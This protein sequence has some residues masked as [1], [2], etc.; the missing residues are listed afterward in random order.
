[1]EELKHEEDEETIEFT[2]LMT[3]MTTE[4]SGAGSGDEN[5][6]IPEA[7]RTASASAYKSVLIPDE[8]I[9]DDFEDEVD[10]SLQPTTIL[11]TAIA[12]RGSTVKQLLFSGL[13]ISFGS[14]AKCGLLGGVAQFLWSQLRKIDTARATFGGL[15][16]MSI[17]NSNE[18]SL[19]D[20]Y[21][22]HTNLWAR[23]FVR[24]HSDMAMSH[25]A[26]FQ[27]SYQRASQDVAILI[28]ESGE[29]A[30]QPYLLST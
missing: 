24:S 25:V 2:S 22:S 29:Q 18:N 23:E 4:T 1:M 5:D 21:L 28:D 26:A 13:S 17:G 10:G 27:K 30:H 9:D 15:Q 3:K 6:N 11:P 7:Y 20:T 12:P 8:G 16:G 14:V 19:R